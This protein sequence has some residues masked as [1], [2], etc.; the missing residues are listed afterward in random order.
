[1]AR[2]R[3]IYGVKYTVAYRVVLGV[4]LVLAGA[5]RGADVDPERAAA[6]RAVAELSSGDPAQRDEAAK[7]LIAMGAEARRPVFEA[8]RS[9]D[10]ELRARAADLLLKLPWYLPDDSPEVRKLLDGYGK[11]DVEKRKDVVEELSK[12]TQ[13][14]HDAL[15]RLI[16][17]EPSD[18]VKWAI[19]STVR[20]SFRDAVL[21]RFRALETQ[22]V[23]NAPVLAAAGH[24]WLPKD[25]GKGEKLLRQ[26]LAVD[27]ERPANDAGEVEAA[28]D[29]LQNLA[30]LAGRYDDEAELL[31]QRARRGGVDEEGEPTKAVLFLFAAHAQYGPLKGFEKD[32]ET[33]RAQLDD[34]RVMFAVGKVYERCGERALAEAIYRSAF[35]VDL[36]SIEDRFSQGEFLMRHGWLDLAEAQIAAV[37]ELAPDHSVEHRRMQVVM[38]PEIDTANAHF[39]M[40]QIAAARS[41]DQRA[42]DEMEQ[43]MDLHHKAR[44]MLRGTTEQE[45]RQKIDWH[46]LR[47]ARAKGDKIASRHA[48]DGLVGPPVTDV[49]IANDVVPMLREMGRADE[50][51]RVFDQ[52]YEAVQATSLERGADHPMPKNNLAWLCARCGERKGEALRLAEEATRAMPDNAAFVDTLAEAHF[53]VGHFSEA[54]RLE[55]KVVGARPSDRFLKEQLKRFQAAAGEANKKAE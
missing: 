23:D 3:R 8:S 49:D 27:Q 13:H 26:A 18:D 17:E 22:D 30:L 41:D 43:A 10:P 14:G 11:L 37:F 51:K 25:V 50:A 16:E 54:V 45:M 7:A 1:M 34:P 12:L 33:Y 39:R 42:A 20:L 19:V 38:T 48:L 55:T 21:E 40:A 32:L 36:V 53:Q 2:G 4:A 46:R 29:R 35:L 9:E 44:G 6:Y 24:A 31:R 15:V 52:A 5:A 28:Y 47:A